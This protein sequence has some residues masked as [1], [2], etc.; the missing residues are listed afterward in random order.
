MTKTKMIKEL[1]LWA[2]LQMINFIEPIEEKTNIRLIG[3]RCSIDRDLPMDI[4]LM[5][6]SLFDLPKNARE[7]FIDSFILR[8]WQCGIIV[9]YPEVFSKESLE[10]A[11]MYLKSY[12]IPEI[13]RVLIP[14]I[15]E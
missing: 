15:K 3:D 6:D 5:A 2:Q 9:K 14:R 4:S 8:P 1:T 10:F 11:H 12:G 13:K 7:P